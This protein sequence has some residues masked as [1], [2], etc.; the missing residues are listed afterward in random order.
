MAGQDV[1]INGASLV[2]R[3]SGVL[4]WPEAR[5]LCVSDLHLGKSERMARRGNVFLPPYETAETLAR[6]GAEIAALAPERVICLG[7]SFDDDACAAALAAADSAR[8][9]SLMA[10]RD[11]IWI[12]GN[13]DGRRTAPGGRHAGEIAIGPLVFRHEAVRERAELGSP[14]EVSGH[15]HPKIRVRAGGTS[16]VRRCFL[17]DDRRIMLPAFGAYTGGLWCDDPAL[18]GLFS[19]AARAILTGRPNLSVPLRALCATAR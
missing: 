19:D 4:W 16:V 15:F 12:E 7:D 8:L 3:A 17:A 2:A 6:L 14:G 5:M 1:N 18:R 13:H 10:G 9:T 11:W